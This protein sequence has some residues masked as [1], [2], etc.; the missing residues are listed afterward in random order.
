[1][2]LELKNCSYKISWAY[3]W[4]LK[5]YT[6]LLKAMTTSVFFRKIAIPL[7]KEKYDNIQIIK[8]A[9]WKK[10]KVDGFIKSIT[11][12]GFDYLMAAD[13]DFAESVNEKKRY[14]SGKFVSVDKDNITV[15]IKEIESWYIAGLSDEK[16]KEFHLEIFHDTENITKETF[17][18]LYHRKFRSRIDFM[19]ELLKNYSV[20]AAKMKNKSFRYFVERYVEEVFGRN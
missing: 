15:V 16:S 8:Y 13:M 1:M 17:K 5:Y 19:K 3:R 14:I 20:D 12:L 9:Q 18:T 6:F 4:F 11:T 10:V 2:K 7:L